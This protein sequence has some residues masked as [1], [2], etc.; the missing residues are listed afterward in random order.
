MHPAGTSSTRIFLL[1]ELLMCLYHLMLADI[2]DLH[3]A[4]M[5]ASIPSHRTMYTNNEL[6]LPTQGDHTST[7]RSP[8]PAVSSEHGLKAVFYI[9][10]RALSGSHTGRSNA[11]TRFP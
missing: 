6:L 5:L 8:Y 3:I 10:C 11:L 4:C 7:R 2:W 1:I 9:H